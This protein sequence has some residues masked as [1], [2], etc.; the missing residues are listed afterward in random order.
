MVEFAVALKQEGYDLDVF[1]S[2]CAPNVAALHTASE[3]TPL[4]LPPVLADTDAYIEALFDACRTQGIDLVVPLSNFDLQA[5]AF[6]KD[7]FHNA[8]I[9]VVVSNPEMISDSL[10]KRRTSIRCQKHGL[11][12]PEAFD[13]PDAVCDRFPCVRK[14]RFGN[15]GA[16]FQVVNSTQDLLG[17]ESDKEI[18]QKYIEGTEYGLDVLNDFEGHFV[19]MCAKKKID[20]RA[21]ETDRCEVVNFP[22]LYGL[23]Q[24]IAE[25]FG[26]IGNM[27]V[28]VISDQNGKFYCLDFNPRFGG[29]Y[30]AS[31]L[32]G[33]NFLRAIIDM[34]QG[35]PLRLPEVPSKI[36]LMKGISL[37]STEAAA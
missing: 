7:R 36:V 12:V 17:F 27:D 33:M 9:T 31:H 24:A 15:S 16:G 34:A 2:D 11:P 30:P 35:T 13:A 26:H 8:G 5:L 1:V 20:M 3:A 19:A 22:A 6:A 29:G 18:L 32:A 37:H 23:G 25:A 28:D 10:D 4:I 21:G 14:D